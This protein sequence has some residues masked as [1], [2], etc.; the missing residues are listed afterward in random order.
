MKLSAVYDP[1]GKMHIVEMSSWP[2]KVYIFDH[3]DRFFQSKYWH[4]AEG[5]WRAAKREGWR[6]AE[7]EFVEKPLT[8]LALRRRKNA[9]K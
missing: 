6:I 4:K 9:C 1:S 7:G 8:F 2:C 3:H 5:A